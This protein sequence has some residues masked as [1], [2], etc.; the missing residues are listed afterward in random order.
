MESQNSGK[1]VTYLR[2]VGELLANAKKN[3]KNALEEI[4][5]IAGEAKIACADRVY[6]VMASV[7]DA[8]L[9]VIRTGGKGIVE[10]SEALSGEGSNMVGEAL[11][12]E[13][14]RISE[15]YES[16]TAPIEES[17]VITDA[18]ISSRGLEENWTT[19]VQNKFSDACMAFIQVRAKLIYNI[20]EATRKARENDFDDVYKTFGRNLENSCN[21]IADIFKK[22]MGEFEAAGINIEKMQNNARTAVSGVGKAD[23]AMAAA[24]KPIEF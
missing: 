11:I 18:T 12:T 9:E 4:H 24:Q 22:H 20:S 15:D 3:T 10:M 13:A 17:A 14:K 5:A 2:E 21:E 23:S 7:A 16:L 1:K 19:A 6:N 8:Q